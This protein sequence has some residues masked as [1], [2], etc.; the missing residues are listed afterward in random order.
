MPPEGWSDSPPPC[1]RTRSLSASRREASEAEA[2][3]EEEAEEGQ[4]AAAGRTA[5]ATPLTS[6]EALP[7]AQAEK[8]VL[9]V[10]ENKAGHHMD[11]EGRPDPYAAR[12][13]R[14]GEHEHEHEHLGAF[15]TGEEAALCA[16]RSAEMG[17]MHVGAADRMETLVLLEA[18]AKAAAAAEEEE[19]AGAGAAA[20]AAAEEEE[21]GAAARH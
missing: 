2:E 11:M 12:G 9:A 4:V 10:A 5:A 6:Q 8:L 21:A 18:V 20:A 1:C 17:G 19:E 13:G 14:R 7:Q 16:A 3:E 15:A